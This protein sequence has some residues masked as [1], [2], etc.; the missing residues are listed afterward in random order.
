MKSKRSAPRAT[1]ALGTGGQLT[2]I[3]LYWREIKDAQPLSRQREIDLFRRAH[4]GDEAARQ[5]LVVANL[6]FVVSVAREYRDYG[7]PLAEL[8]SEGNLGLLEA[9]D[10]F[11]E[12]RGFKFIT[13]AVWW[14]RQAILRA[15]AEHGKIIR[16]PMSQ[17]SDLQKVEKRANALAHELGRAPTHEEILAGVALSKVRTRN[18]LAV[19][20]ADVSLDSPAHADSDMPLMSLFPVEQVSPEQDHAEGQLRTAVRR[21]VNGLAPR[22]SQVLKAYFGLDGTR[23]MTLEEI[24]A[25]MG[26]TRERVRQLRNRALNKLKANH[27]EVLMEFSSN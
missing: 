2:P 9:I 26:I 4:A 23:P 6:R 12:E 24:G 16:P 20:Q 5:Q 8:V 13:Y 15:L 22:E 10:R 11:D 14:I 3:D 18:A 17:I 19:S 1:K 25:T 7:L 21:F 27:G